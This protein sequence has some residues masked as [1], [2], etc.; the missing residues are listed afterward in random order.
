MP[1]ELTDKIF[2]IRA[3]K[4]SLLDAYS[5]RSAVVDKLKS[6]LKE[7][8]FEDIIHNNRIDEYSYQY[9]KIFINSL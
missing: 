4:F 3:N 7:I 8:P 2:Q 6:E 5:E 1:K 9:L